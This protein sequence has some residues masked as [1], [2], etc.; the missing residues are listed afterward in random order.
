MGACQRRE[1]MDLKKK[2]EYVRAVFR[3][4]K[5]LSRLLL[6]LVVGCALSANAAWTR[7]P[8]QQEIER[9]SYTLRAVQTAPQVANCSNPFAS[10]IGRS[11]RLR[12]GESR[13]DSSQEAEV[14]V[15]AEA[16]LESISVEE[17]ECAA[18]DKVAAAAKLAADRRPPESLQG[19]SGS[20]DDGG[21][22]VV[23][24]LERGGRVEVP[25]GDHFC[26]DGAIRLN[27]CACVGAR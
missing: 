10:V 27:A 5:G 15:D 26:F 16:R 12:G 1:D 7:V 8:G 24:E 6:L 22:V 13:D 23:E 17:E 19:L 21:S 20:P 18:E 14:A 11:L 25:A 9:R 3:Q 2:D 4:R